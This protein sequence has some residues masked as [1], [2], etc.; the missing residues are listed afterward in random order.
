MEKI[1]PLGDRI[2]VK[3]I[4]PNEKTEGGVILVNPGAAK[5]MADGV[6]QKLVRVVLEKQKMVSWIFQLPLKWVIKFFS[7]RQL[8]Q[9]LH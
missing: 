6:V 7:Q 8:V 4:E 1:K 3:V 9:V 5:E 2:V